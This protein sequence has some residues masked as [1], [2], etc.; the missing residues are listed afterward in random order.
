MT[1]LLICSDLVDVEKRGGLD[2]QEFCLAMHIVE[3]LDCGSVSTILPM[4]PVEAHVSLRDLQA[5]LQ[6]PFLPSA[7]I[8]PSESHAQELCKMV[9]NSFQLTEDSPAPGAVNNSSRLSDAAELDLDFARLDIKQKGCVSSEVL[10]RFRWRYNIQPFEMTQIWY[11]VVLLDPLNY[12]LI[13]TFQELSAG[14]R[15]CSTIRGYY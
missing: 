15:R 6:Q 10:S 5:S 2:V 3:A 12:I 1:T 8:R 9:S 11:T 14:P 13:L 4:F 7:I